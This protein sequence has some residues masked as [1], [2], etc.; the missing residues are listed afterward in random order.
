MKAGTRCVFGISDP[1]RNGL[2]FLFLFHLQLFE[3][4]AFPVTVQHGFVLVNAVLFCNTLLIHKKPCGHR[5]RIDR[6]N[7]DEYTQNQCDGFLHGV[8]L[9]HY[10]EI[11]MI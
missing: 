5:S 6:L 4:I 10:V 7:G 8:K 9:H 11:D 2:A 3:E 1:F